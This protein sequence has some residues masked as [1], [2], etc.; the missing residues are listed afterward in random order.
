[1]IALASP[2]KKRGAENK[3]GN[4]HHWRRGKTQDLEWCRW[5]NQQQPPIPD[6]VKAEADQDDRTGS[7]DHAQEVDLDLK[8][9]LRPLELEAKHQDRGSVNNQ[10]PERHSPTDI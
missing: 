1:R 4:D 3:T 5:A 7:Q 8:P 2:D 6:I 9:R 10:E